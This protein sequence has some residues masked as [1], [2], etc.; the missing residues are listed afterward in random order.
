MRSALPVVALLATLAG[1]APDLP[2]DADADGRDDRFL[3]GGKAD[4]AGLTPEEIAGV[5]A[6]ANTASRVELDVDARLDARA[7][8][9]LVAHRDGPDGLPGTADDDPFDD[10]AELDAVPWVGPVAL[11]RLLDHA[12]ARGLVPEPGAAPCLIV[13][14]YLEGQG[15][16]NKALELFNCG[17]APV[18]LDGAGVCLVRDA[19][20]TCSRTQMLA[21][22]LAPGAVRT[23]CRT[24]GGTFNDP[25][26]T[27]RDRCQVEAPGV[28]TFSGNDRLVVFRDA[29]G[30]RSFGPGDTVLDALGWIARPPSTE[31]WADVVLRRCR[32]TPFDG[33]SFFPYLSYY[34][35]HARHDHADYGLPPTATACP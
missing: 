2:D 4:G 29:D 31:L 16:N 13:S 12:Y 15:N 21:G 8:R 26:P 17:D 1:C 3:A 25:M 33:A 30:S 18:A 14:E 32:P 20:T 5:L 19:D 28:M 11:A 7:A 9:H 24:R 6:V 23:L 35:R 34:T 27:I 10:L 22:T